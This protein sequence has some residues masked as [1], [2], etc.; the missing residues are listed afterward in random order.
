MSEFFGFMKMLVGAGTL[1][2]IVMLILLSMP[3]SKLRLVGMELCKYA[4]CVA[5]V[6]MIPSPIDVLPDA[7][8]VI[9]WLDDIGYIF[10]AVAAFKSAGG[11]RTRRKRLDDIELAE[12]EARGEFARASKARATETDAST[13][14]VKIDSTLHESRKEVADVS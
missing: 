5:F 8:P 3:Q 1:L 10:G 6:L 13:P 14:K 4:M 12:L 2:F 9:G 11:D 7:V